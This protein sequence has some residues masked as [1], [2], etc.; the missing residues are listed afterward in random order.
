MSEPCDRGLRRSYIPPDL[1]TPTPDRLQPPASHDMITA[2]Q[3]ASA[4]S[5]KGSLVCVGI[6]MTLG[7]H[8]APL[9]RSYIEQADVVFVAVSDGVVEL[10]IAEMHPDVRSLQPYYR[11]RGFAPGQYPE[12]EAHGESAITL[13]LFP[14]LTDG[15]Q[16]RVIDAVR[17]TLA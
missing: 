7:S 15:E 3:G 16:D 8:L 14:T 5:G 4:M 11:E 10:W 17:A 9:A 6:G 13:P 12:A 1:A 2:S